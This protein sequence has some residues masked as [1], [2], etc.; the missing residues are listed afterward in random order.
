M[1][2]SSDIETQVNTFLKP[3]IKFNS[4]Y[5]QFVYNNKWINEVTQ[6]LLRDELLNILK[7][8]T[9]HLKFGKNTKDFLKYLNQLVD[10]RID[11]YEE[12]KGATGFGFNEFKIA[13]IS[14]IDNWDG[15]APADEKFSIKDIVEGNESVI[16]LIHQE[17]SYY[18]DLYRFSKEFNDYSNPMDIELVKI[19]YV[20]KLHYEVI[21]KLYQFVN[22]I[23]E[24]YENINLSE[25][26]FENLLNKHGFT[27]PKETIATIQKCHI[28]L[29]KVNVANLFHL[30]LDEKLIFFHRDEKQNKVLL[31]KFIEKNFTYK[32]DDN[33]QKSVANINKEFSKVNYSNTESHIIFLESF[34]SKLEDRRSRL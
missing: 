14:A 25:F 26:D 27:E 5:N 30:L 3:S 34:I 7:D 12:K 10:K 17:Q 22:E 15:N 4:L 19:N 24:D 32:D 11:F 16:D 28:S 21:I 23:L 1:I 2:L 18:L 20:M 29:N 33:N 13:D 31:Q 6:E 8:I 9:S